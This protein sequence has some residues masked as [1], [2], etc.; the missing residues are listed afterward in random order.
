[1]KT[2]IKNYETI[3]LGTKAY[4]NMCILTFFKKYIAQQ[5]K[6]VSTKKVTFI[7]YLK[8]IK[9]KSNK[10]VLL[11]KTQIITKRYITKT[12]SYEQKPIKIEDFNETEETE[13]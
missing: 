12:N 5:K 13:V 7:L 2:T 4:S 6:A 8:L 11:G 1:M 10:R 9:A 3:Y